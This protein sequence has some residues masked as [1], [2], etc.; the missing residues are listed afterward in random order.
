VAKPTSR[1]NRKHKKDF[2][3]KVKSLAGRLIL[4]LARFCFLFLGIGLHSLIIV[5]NIMSGRMIYYTLFWQQ[6]PT[7]RRTSS[8]VTPV[9][10]KSL[11]LPVAPLAIFILPEPQRKTCPKNLVSLLFASPSTGGAVNLMRRQSPLIPVISFLEAR[12]CTLTWILAPSENDVTQ[13]RPI[14]S[15][16]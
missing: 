5:C 7:R 15:K 10:S 12:G 2:Q 14:T 8:S 11:H 9:I 13:D 1:R 4:F 6:S 16:K 3:N